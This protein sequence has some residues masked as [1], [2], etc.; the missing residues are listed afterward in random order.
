MIPGWKE[1][2]EEEYLQLMREAAIASPGDLAARIGVSECCAVYW[3]TELARAGRIRILA[4]EPVKDGD[5]PCD[6][7]S[8]VTCQRRV[9]CPAMVTEAGSLAESV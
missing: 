3:L 7:Q 1:E 2:L 5:V 4:V 9:T 6:Q 8:F